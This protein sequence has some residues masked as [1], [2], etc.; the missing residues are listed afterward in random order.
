MTRRISRR[1]R[2][3]V[4]AAR[5][6]N[7]AIHM[8]RAREQRTRD[9][10]AGRPTS[11]GEAQRRRDLGLP[12][13]YATTRAGWTNLQKHRADI[14]NTKVPAKVPDFASF[15]PDNRQSQAL[16]DI[17]FPQSDASSVPST[18][19][20]F[21]FERVKSLGRD[22]NTYMKDGKTYMM[23]KG[24]LGEVKINAVPSV[25]IKGGIKGG[26]S[27]L[28]KIWA[29]A[30]AR[31]AKWTKLNKNRRV[32]GKI[33][34]WTKT[35]SHGQVI[36]SITHNT[37]TEKLTGNIIQRTAQGFKNP[38]ILA[39]LVV[40]AV[41]SYAWSGHLN[42]DNIAGSYQIAARDMDKQGFTEEADKLREALHDFENPDLWE[43]IKRHLPWLNMYKTFQA[44]HK[45]IALTNEAYRLA[46][47]ALQEQTNNGTDPD[48][49]FDLRAKE[50]ADYAARVELETYNKKLAATARARH[51][52]DLEEREIAE[53]DRKYYEKRNAE[54][55]Q[56]RKVDLENELRLRIEYHKALEKLQEA[57]APSKLNF[58]I[59]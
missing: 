56:Q 39:G 5:N 41:Y 11:P 2:K 54:L 57:S 47:Q 14:R 35:G 16:G 1:D 6:A 40:S 8:R 36:D 55:R 48:T 29:Q 25:G 43:D 52:R 24:E 38:M 59:V 32:V 44:G 18:P 9:R 12:M 7:H 31:L 17:A 33:Q 45:Q 37:Y 51:A 34:T 4:Q 46:D 10:R 19:E 28:P 20:E 58:G 3:R 13:K 26:I 50:R 15:A 30:S 22:T 27:S 53:A 49:L 21:G 42:L 23:Y